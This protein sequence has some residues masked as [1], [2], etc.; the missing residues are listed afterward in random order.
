[1]K[2][3]GQPPTLAG[4]TAGNLRAGGRFSP[5]MDT[6]RAVAH[7]WIVVAA[8]AYLFDLWRQTAVGLT[9]GSG[10]PFG[11]D[12]INYYS[13]AKLAVLGR[14]DEVFNL[15]AFNAF[16]E[17]VVGADVFYTGVSGPIT[18]YHYGYP[19]VLILL[20][21]PLA[22]LPYAPALFVWL[23]T[24]WYAFY[25]ALHIAMP[26]GALLLALAAPAVFLNAMAG[27]NGFW[28]AALLGGGLVLLERRPAVAGILFGL[29]IFKPHLGLLIPVALLAGRQWRAF[30][31]AALTALLALAASL[32]AFGADIWADFLRTTT[33][34]RHVFL[35]GDAGIHHRLVSVFTAARWLGA[36]VGIAYIVQAVSALIAAAIVA[37]AWTRNAP[38]PLRYTLLVLGT[39]ITTPYLLDYDLV[40]SAFAVAWL[41]AYAGEHPQRWR[42]VLFVSALAL[43]LPILSAPLGRLTGLS[44]GGLFLIAAYVPVAAMLREALAR[45]VTFQ[46]PGRG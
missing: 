30:A 32:A 16:Q 34:L 26:N 41:T 44:V 20:T 10:R 28:T 1:M 45:P 37:V 5:N 8:A 13:A 18:F 38:A 19:P 9:D 22:A 21:L 35:E 24:G 15:D 43:T 11:D 3:P 2:F 6:L 12:F 17:A 40:A 31:A 42:T 23:G 7:C 4:S 14:V 36:S 25:R 27:Q 33:L 46:T 29:L 39:W